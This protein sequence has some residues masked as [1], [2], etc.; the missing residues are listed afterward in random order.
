V[1]DLHVCVW[2][3]DGTSFERSDTLTVTD[4]WEYG[5]ESGGCRGRQPG[6]TLR[7]PVAHL[8]AW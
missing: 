7:P 6:Q 2:L 1:T 3:S 4:P 8:S 5:Q